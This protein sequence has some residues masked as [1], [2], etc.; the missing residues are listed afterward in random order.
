[1]AKLSSVVKITL[2]I[3]LFALIALS[4]QAQGLFSRQKVVNQYTTVGIGGG[5]SHYY[6]DLAPY[7][8]FYYG[9]YTNVRWNASINY[10]RYLT[11]QAAAR[12]QF[13][14][15][16]IAG[17]DY[18]FAS[19]NLDALGGNFLRNFSFRNDVK[20]FTLSGLFNI[21]PQYGKGAKGRNSVMPYFIAGIGFYGHNPQAKTPVDPTLNLNI[22]P[23]QWINLR[24]YSTSGQNLATNNLKPYSLV[25]FVLPTGIGVRL[26]INDKWDFT[27][28]GTLHLTPF[29]YL[30]DVGGDAAY[31][32]PN[33]LGAIDPLSAALSNRSKEAFSSTGK[34]RLPEVL[35]ILQEKGVPYTSSDPYSSLNGLLGY[36]AKDPANI[37]GTKR[38]DS[39]FLTQFTIS[40]IISGNVKCP[41]IK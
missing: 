33:E 22:E 40:Y 19:R 36:G 2:N 25:Q 20:E 41:I 37:R 3:V 31:P 18:T 39:Y 6:G 38:I 5:S 7:S 27:A 14:W 26:K 23:N 15:A 30:D 34:T 29:D 35:Q 32:D 28:E 10:T 24:Q 8:Q 16:R 17:D 21:L 11:P 12:V 1:M 4:S 13:T 9:F